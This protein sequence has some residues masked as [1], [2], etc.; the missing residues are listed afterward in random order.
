MM[1]LGVVNIAERPSIRDRG[2]GRQQVFEHRFRFHR[3]SGRGLVLER[4]LL[5][6]IAYVCMHRLFQERVYL[7]GM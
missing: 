3:L 5:L 6:E 7:V 1:F 2:Y 4:Y